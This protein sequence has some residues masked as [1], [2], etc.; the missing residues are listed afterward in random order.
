[1]SSKPK[2]HGRAT[3]TN[4]P[5]DCA[6]M[7]AYLGFPPFRQIS[8]SDPDEKKK[9]KKRERETDLPHERKS[10]GGLGR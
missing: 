7:V 10:D 5:R 9:K 8:N 6:G 2:S 1:M 3:R 4:F